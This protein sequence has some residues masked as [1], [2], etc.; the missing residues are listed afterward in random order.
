[1]SYKFWLWIYRKQCKY[2][3]YYYKIYSK[4]YYYRH[5]RRLVLAFRIWPWPLLNVHVN[6][7]RFQ[8]WKIRLNWAMLHFDVCQRLRCPFLLHLTNTSNIVKIE[9]FF[10]YDIWIIASDNEILKVKHWAYP[11]KRQRTNFLVTTA[12]SQH[13][14]FFWYYSD[15]LAMPNI[16]YKYLNACIK[17]A[18]I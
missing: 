8:L 18:G 6:V 4:Y 2:W 12:H 9:I 5:I 10:I 13:S 3:A 14:L 1:M 7:I 16:K 11:A 17:T 15:Q